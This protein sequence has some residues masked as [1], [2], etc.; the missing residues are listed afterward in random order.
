MTEASAPSFQVKTA[1]TH[2]DYLNQ[3]IQKKINS[4]ARAINFRYKKQVMALKEEI[5]SLKNNFP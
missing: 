5:S 1:V 2:T 4:V 3:W